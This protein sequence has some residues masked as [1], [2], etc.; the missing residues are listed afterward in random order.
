MSEPGHF[1]TIEDDYGEEVQLHGEED[2]AFSIGAVKSFESSFEV[3]LHVMHD[4]DHK[5][6]LKAIIEKHV[7]PCQSGNNSNGLDLAELVDSCVS[8][9][10]K[11]AMDLKDLILLKE[12]QCLQLSTGI[13]QLD[14]LVDV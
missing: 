2:H 1:K 7:L 12:L 11:H 3:C 9:C 13:E 14:K 10:T 4:L 6:F 8:V 5:A